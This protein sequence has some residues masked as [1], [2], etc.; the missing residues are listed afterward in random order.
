[1]ESSRCRILHPHWG[2]PTHT[3]E[4]FAAFQHC[5][6]FHSVTIQ[7]EVTLDYTADPAM[8]TAQLTDGL[9]SFPTTTL[10]LQVLLVTQV[11]LAKPLR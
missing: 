7:S 4:D 3:G 5:L 10:D 11:V 8:W 9:G 1:M 6:T 2:A